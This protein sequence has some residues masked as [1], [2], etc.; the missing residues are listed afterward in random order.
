MKKRWNRIT[1]AV[2]KIDLIDRVLMLFMAVLFASLAFSLFER[3]AAPEEAASIDTMV[4]TSASAIFGYFI[5]GNF[6]KTGSSPHP[7]K[8]PVSSGEA[9]SPPVF[10]CSRL[11]I[12]IVSTVG[13][14]SLLLL[15]IARNYTVLTPEFSATASQLRDFTA[16]AIG[17]LVSC[18]KNQETPDATV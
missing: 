3:G 5:S 10:C 14:V 6:L 12:V 1:E 8:T 17:Y 16:A 2:S 15:L 18:G 4:R 11:Q 13:L 9:S 7:K